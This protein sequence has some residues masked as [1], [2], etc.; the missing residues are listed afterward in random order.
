[1]PTRGVNEGFDSGVG[2]SPAVAE[3]DETG[4][5]TE[6]SR[7]AEP[8]DAFAALGLT[9]SF[10]AVQALREV[11]LSVSPGEIH[12]LVGSNGSG[13][14]T[15]IKIVCGV[16]QADAG[17]L[18]FPGETFET[19]SYSAADAHRSGVRVV[20]QDL[21]IF[22]DLTVAENLSI[23]EGF[24][25]TRYGRIR[26]RAMREVA[27]ELIDRFAIPASPHTKLSMLSRAAQTQVAIARALQDRKSHHEGLLILDEP[28]ASLPRHEAEALLDTLQRYAAEGQSILYVSHRLDEILRITGRVTCLRDGTV[29]LARST[30][31]MDESQ[32]ARALVGREV[33]QSARSDRSPQ[34]NAGDGTMP[35]PSNPRPILQVRDLSS[36]PLRKINLHV[37]EGEVVG[38]AGLL[39]SG[40]SELLRAI[41]GDARVDSGSVVLEGRPVR[42]TTPRKAMRAGVAFVPEDR[43]GDAAFPDLP[44]YLND[45][46][47][48]VSKYWRRLTI[49]TS[50]MRRDSQRL[51]SRFGVKARNESVPLSHLS[52]GNQQKVI[53]AR[54]LR[55]DPRLL[56]LDEPSQGVDVGAREDIYS[57]I[58]DAVGAGAGALVVASDL[59]ELARVCD[60]VLILRH[61][62]VVAEVAPPEINSITL[63]QLSY[64]DA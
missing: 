9:K 17:R 59:E 22:P 39:G 40:R 23:G 54:W 36:G 34:T 2:K 15:L 21:G 52:G 31:G 13:K 42:L 3:V 44:I 51:S 18:H 32:L 53:M 11:S 14:S 24:P 47:G 7:S 48:M 33:S 10:G 63:T 12:G 4:P 49:R 43:A 8:Q 27:D 46:A 1:M 61:G 56:L 29:T 30:A 16:Y 28:T 62:A 5:A 35:A 25:L 57:F 20:H 41:F 37:N 19:E 38:V 45:T 64:G 58:F 55:R 6:G 60:R 50:A 26:G